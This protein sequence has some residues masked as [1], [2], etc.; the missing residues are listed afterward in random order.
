MG[1]GTYAKEG[2]TS[3]TACAKGTADTDKKA[4]TPC[5][6]CAAGSFAGEGT[7]SCTKCGSGKADT[8][9]NPA[10]PCE[11]CKDGFVPNDAATKCDKEKPKGPQCDKVFLGPDIGWANVMTYSDKDKSCHLSL[12]E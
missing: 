10:T 11:A 8:D 2:S 6:K 5:K 7:T 9:S 4:S 3:C 12:Q 1:V